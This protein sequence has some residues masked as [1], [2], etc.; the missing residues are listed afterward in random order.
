MRLLVFLVFKY[1]V[2]LQIIW[3]RTFSQW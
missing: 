2:V 1:K 3:E